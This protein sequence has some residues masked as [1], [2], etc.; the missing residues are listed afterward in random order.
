MTIHLMVG[1]F[2]FAKTFLRVLKH[3]ENLFWKKVEKIFDFENLWPRLVFS[4]RRIAMRHPRSGPLP[5]DPNRESPPSLIICKGEFPPL[6]SHCNTGT[7]T[8]DNALKSRTFFSLK[9]ISE[10]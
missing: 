3:E 1:K 9:L 5:C 7:L 10:F 8:R 4:Y 2:F 6:G